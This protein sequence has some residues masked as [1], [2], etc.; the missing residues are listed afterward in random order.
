MQFI[1]DVA[2]YLANYSSTEEALAG[3]QE[4]YQAYKLLESRL[5]Q[6]R[7]K[8]MLKV[9]DVQ[10]TLACVKTLIERKNAEKDTNVD[11]ELTDGIFAHAKVTAD[12]ASTVYLWLGANVALEYT[13]EEAA[14]LL[15]KN[16]ETA[17]ANLETNRRDQVFIKDNITTTEV[18]MARIYNH[19]V[20]MKRAKG[21]GADASA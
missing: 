17:Q 15:Q 6:R 21:A 13:V 7:Q 16:L 4:Q 9:P 19:D 8:L 3:L 1:E 10:R 11:F 2:A 12:H 20:A 14:E 5:L 18:S